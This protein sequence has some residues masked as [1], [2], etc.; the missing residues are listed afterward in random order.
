M[1]TLNTKPNLQN[2]DTFYAALIQ[3]HDG[4]TDDKSAALNARLI[5]L[6]SN[7]IGDAQVLDQV[8]K[9]AKME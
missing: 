2:A 7:H 4:L 9:A 8:L 3:I 1:A 6:L 5:L